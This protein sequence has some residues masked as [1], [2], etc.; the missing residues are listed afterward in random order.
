MAGEAEIERKCGEI[1]RV[2]QFDERPRHSQLRQVLMQGHALHTTEEIREVRRRDS[3]RS[4]DVREQ[5]AIRH[6]RLED[7]LR[8]SNQSDGLCRTHALAATVLLERTS[9]KTQ[10]QLL[11]FERVAL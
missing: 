4:S 10:N 5:N 1:V 6:L 11:G 8:A 7:F 3:D 9:H 2:R